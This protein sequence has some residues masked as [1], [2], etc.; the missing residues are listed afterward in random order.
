MRI[1]VIGATGTI[2]R[3]VLAA[4]GGRH[5]IIP[6]SRQKAREKVD[7]ADLA[8]LRALLERVGRGDAIVSAAGHSAWKRLATLTDGDVALS[9][10]NTRMG[11]RNVPRSGSAPLHASGWL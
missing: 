6:A 11:P 1:L 4:L 3:A 10:G 5:E 2:G 9:V 7:I 8:A